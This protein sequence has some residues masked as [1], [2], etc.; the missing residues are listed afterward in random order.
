MLTKFIGIDPGKQ[1]SISVI[2][3]E[4]SLNV[5]PVP[6]VNDDYD[7]RAMYTLLI[8][9]KEGAFAI[10]E[11]AQAMPGQ[12]VSSMF[13][14]GRGYGMWLMALS[15][16]EIPFQIV[17]PR[18]WTRIMLAG[19][20]GEGKERSF[21]VARQLFPQWNPKLKKEY[22]YSDSILLAEY[23]RRLQTGGVDEGTKKD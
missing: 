14:F 7:L 17:H 8:Q 1:G 12:G 16:S 6:V 2:D 18:V 23:G 19:A 15:I 20:E 21:S 9:N 10:L 13:N 11:R 5:Y 3:L 4:G 22:Q